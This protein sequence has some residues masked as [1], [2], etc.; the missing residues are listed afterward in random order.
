MKDVED[1]EQFCTLTWVGQGEEEGETL[2]CALWIKVAPTPPPDENDCCCD[3]APPS[4]PAI[5]ISTCK[6]QDLTIL[7]VRLFSLRLKSMHSVL[8][9]F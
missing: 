2:C 6:V 3:R 7:L 8:V 1:T 5:F 9:T 4:P